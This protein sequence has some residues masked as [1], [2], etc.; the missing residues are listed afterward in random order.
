MILDFIAQSLGSFE[1]PCG[2]HIIGINCIDESGVIEFSHSRSFAGT[3]H[4][5]DHFSAIYGSDEGVFAGPRISFI[6]LAQS[7]FHSDIFEGRQLFNLVFVAGDGNVDIRFGSRG[8][9]SSDHAHTLKRINNFER[10][11][12]IQGTF[13]L[14]DFKRRDEEIVGIFLP[15]RDFKIRD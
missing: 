2:R 10:R 15:R 12:F 13:N 7:E 4:L 1:G 11:H 5:G 8:G 9:F 6:L 14:R 3:D